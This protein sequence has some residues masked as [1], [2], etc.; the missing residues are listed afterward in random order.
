MEDTFTEGFYKMYRDLYWWQIRSLKTS[1][2][3]KCLAAR[4]L[5]I[6]RKWR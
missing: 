6:M 2:K 5:W 1:F 4:S 3:V